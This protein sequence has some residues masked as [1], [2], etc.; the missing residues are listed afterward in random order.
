LNS[1]NF[2]ADGVLGLG[3]QSSS[4]FDSPTIVN[5]LLSQGQITSGVFAFKLVE[6]DSELTIGGL[7]TDLYSGTPFY[8]PLIASGVWQIQLSVFVVNG[9]A[10]VGFPATL[11]SVR[12][13][14][15]LLFFMLINLNRVA[16][17]PMVP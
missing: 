7:N 10:V 2:A 6:G 15:T 4:V 5:N 12:L 17:S 8:T 11:T 16:L 1:D 3:F 14:S 13:E 9:A